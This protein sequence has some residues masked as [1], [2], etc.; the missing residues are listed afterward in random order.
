M[1]K[2]EDFGVWYNTIATLVFMGGDLYICDHVTEE[3]NRV[4][5]HLSG[6]RAHELSNLNSFET[7]VKPDDA[8]CHL[9]SVEYRC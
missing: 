1:L 8:A 6:Q 2:Q 4:Q 5:A 7:L 9:A 3:V